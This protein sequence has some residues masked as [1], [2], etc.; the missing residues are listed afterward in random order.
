MYIKGQTLEK[1]GVRPSK[2][3]EELTLEYRLVCLMYQVIRAEL[4]SPL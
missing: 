2:A 1:S 3:R 4:S